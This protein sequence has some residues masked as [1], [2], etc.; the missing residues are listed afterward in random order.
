[1]G[2]LEQAAW[3]N[4][5]SSKA[6]EHIPIRVM[7]QHPLSTIMVPAQALLNSPLFA[8]PAMVDKAC[9]AAASLQLEVNKILLPELVPGFIANPLDASEYLEAVWQ[10]SCEASQL[11]V[12]Q[13]S[14]LEPYISYLYIYHEFLSD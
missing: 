8:D 9:M 10:M 5:S 2:H 4:L 3:L 11:H 13:L 14:E 1:L 6:S 12:S 7:R